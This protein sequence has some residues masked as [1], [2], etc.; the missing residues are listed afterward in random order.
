MAGVMLYGPEL[1]AMDSATSAGI[2][3]GIVELGPSHRNVPVR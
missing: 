2:G 1:I 3:N